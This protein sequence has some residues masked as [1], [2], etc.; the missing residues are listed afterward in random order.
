MV[1]ELE[2]RR[3]LNRLRDALVQVD[4]GW[5]VSI[6]RQVY[7]QVASSNPYVP[8][9]TG[10]IGNHLI[11]CTGVVCEVP[12]ERQRTHYRRCLELMN[13]IAQDSGYGRFFVTELGHGC[14]VEWVMELPETLLQDDGD[15]LVQAIRLGIER[16]AANTSRFYRLFE[17]TDGYVSAIYDYD[18]V[19]PFGRA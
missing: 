14:R 18:E 2:Y 4:A 5:R 16:L 11:R 17:S 8:R 3:S 19:R 9:F 13:L 10:F 12:E 15:Y 6:Y 7:V 1:D